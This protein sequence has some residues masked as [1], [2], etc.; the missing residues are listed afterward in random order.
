MPPKDL[1]RVRVGKELAEVKGSRNFVALI[2]FW[3]LMSQRL[4][5]QIGTS[6]L[7]GV[8]TDPSGATIAK[9]EVTL[10][11]ADEE[12]VRTALS[13][14][15]GSY[16]IPTLPP[17]RYRL[18]VSAKGFG[19]QETQVF[20][21]SSGQAGSLNVTLQLATQTAQVVVQD[22]PA[23][24]QT[25]SASVGSALSSQEMTAI[26]LLGRSFLNAISLLPGTVPVPP[27]GSTTNHSPVNQSVMPSVFGQRQKDNNFLMDGVE[28][29][30][31]NLLGV[32]IYPPPEA[33]QEMKID[34]G[35][36]S[37]AYGHA[38]GAT[39]DVVTKSGTHAWHGDGWEY[40]R[41]NVLD[42]RSFF[43]PVGAY[44]WNQ[45]GG[46][47][48]GPLAI[49]KL[50][51]KD[52]RWYI[53]GYYEGVRIH[54][55]ANYQ[56]FVPTAAQLSGNF[57]GFTTIYNPFSTTCVGSKCT[58]QAFP[59][60]QI[61]Q[62]MLNPTAV[63]VAKAILPLPNLAP[64]TIPGTNYLNTGGNT[65]NGNQWDIRADHEF[66]QH[67]NFFGRYTGADN[68]SIGV[69]LPAVTG[70]TQDRLDNAV[71]GDTHIFSPSF[72]MTLRYGLEGV[73]YRTGTI[74]PSGLAESSGL[75]TVFPEFHG[76][77]VL[78]QITINGYTGVPYSAS[79]I[80]PVYQHSGVV[81][82]QKVSSEHTIEFGGSIVHTSAILDD[83]TSTNVDFTT[84]QTAN[85]N[86]NT[87]DGLA[88]FLLGVPDSARRQIGGSSGNITTYGY[89][90]YGQ[91]TWRHR[92][93]TVNFGLRYDY[94]APPVNS[95]GLGTFNYASG[96]Y[97]W[98][99]T[100]P[101]T[102]AAPN[103][104]AGGI[105]PDRNNFAPRLGLAYQIS[106]KTVVRTS[107]GI[108]YDSFGSNYIQ[109]SQSARGNWPFSFPQAV[110]GI[111][112]T[113]VNAVLPN[114]FPGNPQGSVTPLICSQCLNV[115]T[116]SSR[117]P[118]VAEWTFSVQHQIGSNFTVEASY[119][120]S[121]GTKLTAQIV[122][123]T[124]VVAGLGPYSTRQLYPQFAPYVQN[125]FNEF[126]SW[127]DGG[128]LRVERRFSR[129]LS[130]LLSYTYSK[131]IDYVD[132]LSSG[133]VGGQVTS[134]PTR[135]NAALNRGLAG[136][137]LRHVLVFSFVWDIPARTQH[138]L[139]DAVIAGWQ[140]SNIVTFHS[141][142]PYSVFVGSDIEQIGTIGGRYTEYPNL[143]GNPAL[144]NQTPA[145]W[146]NT[147]AF[148]SP[149]L[150]TVGNA[151]RNILHSDSL[152]DDDLAISKNWQIRERARFELRGE[153]FNL[154]NNVN[155]GFP[156]QI[157]G[158]VQ[159]GTVSSTLNS[160]RQVQVAAKIHF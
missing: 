69:G 45:F 128:A 136:F 108:F 2:C 149:A 141:G 86:G 103:I 21:L 101:V 99:R 78:P 28:N 142:L 148:A 93:L 48:G 63:T 56:G 112:T 121:K 146:F 125:G 49:P 13:G 118:Y 143:V 113:T 40:L 119:F 90:F 10:R 139:L 102:S 144:S 132:N 25:T 47:L 22:T 79:I 67:D 43:T 76:A 20:E 154:F 1:Q 23:L 11:S 157:V 7:S 19:S 37:S 107:G 26:P 3:F 59:N 57:A 131:N 159:F 61:P 117:T 96:T 80:G 110:S 27:A 66:G 160:G 129:G 106:P 94:N 97:V 75:G 158:T 88:S 114:P 38:S 31:P 138:R 46:A 58:R 82:A 50:L 130:F 133:N 71:A 104:R 33:I 65:N 5:A 137:D 52:R 124:A 51:S 55:A 16:V 109:A 60:N 87:G 156:G 34:S 116:S 8:I 30:D 72:V 12:S 18:V 145:Q 111:N 120:G 54:S 17:G 150:G 41:N 39:V 77:E 152:I 98:D 115:E 9:A 62:S 74:F 64:G 89:G 85:F 95:Y 122:D 81:D 84:A 135:F 105:A 68:P 70:T 42:A 140:M 24:L 15:D 53:F 147:S 14:S 126:G 73:N 123:N 36:G 134:N 29:R 127:Y 92:Q 32:A 4:L 100:N 6:S 83:T 35:V 44:R 155:F 91:D 153:F 151:G